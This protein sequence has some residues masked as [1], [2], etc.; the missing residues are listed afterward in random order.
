MLT[1]KITKLAVALTCLFLTF[2][3]Y[4]LDTPTPEEAKKYGIQFI[5]VAD[6]YKLHSNQAAIFCD[7][8]IVREYITETLPEAISCVYE[9][10][11][12]RANKIA[13]FNLSIEQ[14]DASNLTNKSLP[15]VVF[16]NAKSCWRSYKA[17]AAAKQQG[18]TEVWWLR[19]GVPG[20]KQA[21]HPVENN[22]PL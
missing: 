12:G 9:E 15:L 18:F 22:C 6:A 20:W 1:N 13:D 5:S 11:G 3:V 19:D 21:G 10:A 8:R 2:S 16:C 17:A 14:W 4:A 7:A